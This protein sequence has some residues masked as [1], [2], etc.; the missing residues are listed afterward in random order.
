MH[1]FC[2]GVSHFCLCCRLSKNYFFHLIQNSLAKCCT[3]LQHFLQ[4]MSGDWNTLG[5]GRSTFVFIVS[6]LIGVNAFREVGSFSKLIVSGQLF[7]V[8]SASLMNVKS[9][10]SLSWEPLV[11]S[12]VASTFYPES[13]CRSHTLPIWL[14]E[15]MIH[16]KHK[17][18][19]RP[20]L[21]T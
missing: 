11:C 7:T 20:S 2:L 10:S 16:R 9:T 18:I 6:R 19:L 17:P 8:S 1:V 14:A 4:Y 12:L 5:G 13:I 3:R 15:G 21:I